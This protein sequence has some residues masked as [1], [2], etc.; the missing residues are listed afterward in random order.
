MEIVADV[1]F[2]KDKNNKNVP[3]EIAIVSLKNDFVAHWIVSAVH[4]IDS[5]PIEVRQEN[6]QLSQDHHGLEYLEGNITLKSLQ[7]TLVDLLKNVEKTYVRGK[8]KWLLF[9][10]L[11]TREVI[12][13]EYDTNCPSFNTLP[14]TDK[15]CLNHAVKRNYTQFSCA[16]DLA[17]RLKNHLLSKTQ[18]NSDNGFSL[19]FP[20]MFYNEQPT[21]YEQSDT[22]ATAYRRCVPGRSDPVGVDETDGVCIQHR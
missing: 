11:T 7:R 5:L 12:N 15:F 4:R 20:L 16:L 21:D 8:D 18:Q 6:N 22:A 13:L 19:S 10:K 14:L 1:L 17:N 9:H 2:C 3:K